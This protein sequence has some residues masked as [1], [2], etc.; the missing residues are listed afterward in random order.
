MSEKNTNTEPEVPALVKKAP[1]L[2]PLWDWWVKEGRSTLTMLAIALL[3][4]VAFYGG[5]NWLRR[6]DA[7]ANA[8]LVADAMNRQ[9]AEARVENLESAVS[10]YGSTKI[11][12]KLRILL[13]KAYYDRERYQDA[14][15]T[16]DEIVKKSSTNPEFAD[17]AVVGRAYALEGLSKYAEAGD[18]FTAFAND[19]ANTNSYL[20]L[21]AQLGAAR[22]KALAGDKDAA[23]K[24]LETLKEGTTDDVEKLRVENMIDAIKRH[25]PTRAARSLFDKAN[26]A[27]ELIASEK[28]KAPATPK[29]EEAPKAAAPKTEAPKAAAPKAEKPKVEPPKAAAPKT[30]ENVH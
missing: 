19:A 10:S 1:E 20:R 29:A 21:T 16:Y 23:V 8:A 6:R 28:D 5:R 7:A 25:D 30:S 17:I 13:A 14:L 24:E 3:A 4:V 12:A 18:A 26:D 22:C 9:G 27:A 11:G 15:D 2:L